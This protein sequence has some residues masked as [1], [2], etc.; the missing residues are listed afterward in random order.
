MADYPYQISSPE[1]N[2]VLQA[3][4]SCRHPRKVELDLLEAGYTIRLHGK[5]LTKT[6]IRKETGRR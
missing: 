6:E 1:G 2:V 3:P 5:R 4:E